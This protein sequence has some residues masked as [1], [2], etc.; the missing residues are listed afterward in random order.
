MLE[1]RTYRTPVIHPDQDS[2]LIDPE[3]QRRYRSG[4]GILLYS[5]KFSRPDPCNFVR[6][7]SEYMD[8]VM[9]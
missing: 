4:F 1:K 7:L 3:L 6:E 9:M 5:R 2:E 8:G